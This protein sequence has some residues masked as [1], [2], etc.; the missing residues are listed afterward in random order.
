MNINTQKLL[1]LLTTNMEC[2]S[3]TLFAICQMTSRTNLTI[4]G[5]T[6]RVKFITGLLI[7]YTRSLKIKSQNTSI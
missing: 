2:T 3:K 4:I 6:P 1:Y 7:P 5:T